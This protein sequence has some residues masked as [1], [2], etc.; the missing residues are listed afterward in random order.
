M[1]LDCQKIIITDNG[2]CFKAVDSIDFHNKLSVRIE[3]SS[4]YNHQSAGLI[5]R[6]VQTVKQI[7]TKNQQNAWLIMLIF[8]A[9]W[10]PEINKSVVKLLN[11]TKFRTNLPMIDLNQR[12]MNEPEIEKLVNEHQSKSTF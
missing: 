8:K 4:A 2:P 5:E 3:N 1:T 12:N 11:S 10:I 7:M 6:M 9:M